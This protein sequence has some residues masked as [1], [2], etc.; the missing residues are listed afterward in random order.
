MYSSVIPGSRASLIFDV[1]IL[2]MPLVLLAIA[3]SIY[4][5][6]IRRNFAFHRRIQYIL[7]SI[8]LVVVIWF[9]IEIRVSGWHHRAQASPY[10]GSYLFPFLYVH[11]AFA[12]S[13]S[14]AWIS[15]VWL[16]RKYIA[17]N[18]AVTPHRR[19]LHRKVGWISIGLMAL[20][21]LTGW[22]FYYLA[23]CAV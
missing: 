11:V 19:Q 21:T 12:V 17:P 16:A 4:Q 14:A 9:E 2:A 5:A 8:L 6:R 22:T 10:Y 23:F 20:T 18:F 1:L 3:F 7:S 13:V 15:Q